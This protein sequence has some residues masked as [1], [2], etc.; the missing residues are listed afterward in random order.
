MKIVEPCKAVTR[1]DTTREYYE[2]HAFAYASET[3]SANLNNE[4]NLFSA[5]LAL[6]ARI[7]DVGCGAGRDLKNL[8]ERGFGTIGLDRSFSLTQIAQTVSGEPLICAD[9]RTLPLA[10]ESFDAVWASASLLH[11]RRTQI[12]PALLEIRRVVRAGGWLGLTLKLGRGEHVDDRGRFVA[13]YGP[14]EIDSLLRAAA[15]IPRMSLRSQE[16]RGTEIIRWQA[17]VASR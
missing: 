13:L 10:T 14:S 11:L 9:L 4:L 6:G 15:W 7:L 3:L 2:E 8:H 5:R 12:I 1:S 16:A 17:T